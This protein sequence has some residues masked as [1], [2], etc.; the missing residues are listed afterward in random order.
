MAATA[1][2]AE[3]D[4]RGMWQESGI[5]TKPSEVNGA[6]FLFK[7]QQLDDKMKKVGFHA[8]KVSV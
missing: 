6:R 4:S 1:S 3:E 8:K 5:N 7:Q 2:T